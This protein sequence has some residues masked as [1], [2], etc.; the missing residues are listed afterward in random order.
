MKN[1]EQL[2]LL[3]FLHEAEKLKTLLRHSWLDQE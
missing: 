1:K 3:K 2:K